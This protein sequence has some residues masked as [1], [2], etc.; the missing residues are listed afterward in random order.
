MFSQLIRNGKHDGINLNEGT[1]RQGEKS[2][3]AFL[4]ELTELDDMTVFEPMMVSDLS[5]KERKATLNLLVI[6]R[7]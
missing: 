6:I 3:E 2:I 4:T 1:R 7:E 5:N